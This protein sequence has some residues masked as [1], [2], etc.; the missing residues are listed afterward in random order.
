MCRRDRYQTGPAG[1][2]YPER[3]LATVKVA[4]DP[5]EATPWPTTMGAAPDLQDAEVALEREVVFSEDTSTNQFFINGREFDMDTVMFTPQLGTVEEWTITNT[6]DEEHPFHIHVND[7][8][9]MSINGTP[10]DATSLQDIIKLPVGGEVVIRMRF[11]D[12]TGKYVFHCHI[13]AHEDGGMMAALAVTTDGKTP[14][15]AQQAAWGQPLLEP[16][17]S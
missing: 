7:F 17:H 16:H 10:Y 1:D 8:Q 2:D 15:D 9:V 5:V 11:L 4:G 6:A 13:L 14:S 12:F 3:V